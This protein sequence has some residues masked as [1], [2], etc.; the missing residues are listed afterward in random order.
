MSPRTR[1]TGREWLGF[2]NP[3]Q[4]CI[5]MRI[6]ARQ[7]REL[8]GA[9]QV[10]RG[11]FNDLCATKALDERAGFPVGAQKGEILERGLEI[12][13]FLFF[14]PLQF[15]LGHPSPLCSFRS[16]L[17]GSLAFLAIGRQLHERSTAPHEFVGA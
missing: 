3:L 15:R 13:V 5:H 4:V 1:R 12:R 11:M 8:R 9:Q 2:L 7:K 10:L 16:P 6:V 14:A 17:G